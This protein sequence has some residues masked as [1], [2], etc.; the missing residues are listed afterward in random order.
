[1]RLGEWDLKDKNDCQN[2]ICSDPVRNVKIKEII[3]HEKYD[4]N[5][6]S[7]ENDIALLLLE[8]SVVSTR[9]IK[10]IC[11]PTK[12]NMKK[13]SYVNVSMDV[14]GWGHTSSSPNGKRFL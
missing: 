2:G 3:L 6:I 5:S 4:A 11:L 12:K 9:W 7:H 13:R 1:M 10:P 14:A 8:D